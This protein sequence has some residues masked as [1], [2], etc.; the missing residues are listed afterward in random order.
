MAHNVI[1]SLKNIENSQY[2]VDEV[3]TPTRSREC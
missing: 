1:N 3:E 2:A